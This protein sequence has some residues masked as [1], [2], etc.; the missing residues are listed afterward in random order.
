MLL[1]TREGHD[2]MG[3]LEEMMASVATPAGGLRWSTIF[4]DTFIF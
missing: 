4:R 3:M 1:H 2:D